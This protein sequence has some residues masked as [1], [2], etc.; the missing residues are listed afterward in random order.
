MEHVWSTFSKTPGYGARILLLEH[1]VVPLYLSH[2]SLF[3]VNQKAKRKPRTVQI[4]KFQI[5]FFIQCI[6][7]KIKLL[8]RDFQDISYNLKLYQSQKCTFQ[9]FSDIEKIL[10]KY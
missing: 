8:T 4:V 6:V 1:A 9:F 5:P 7:L 2:S 3:Q 10:L